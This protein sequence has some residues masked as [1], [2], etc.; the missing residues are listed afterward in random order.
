MR[1][2]ASVKMP[3]GEAA[4]RYAKE[5]AVPLVE[6]ARRFGISRERVRQKWRS[7]YGDEPTPAHQVRARREAAIVSLASQGLAPVEI[8]DRLGVRLERVYYVRDRDGL[9]MARGSD[10]INVTEETHAKILALA[11]EK[12]TR[13]QIAHELGMNYGTICRHLKGCS[14]RVP[15]RRPSRGASAMASDAMDRTG[16]SLGEAAAKFAVAPPALFQYRKRRGLWTR[17]NAS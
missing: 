14:T 16:C 13:S 12:K 10:K 7:I 5:N 6:A 15:G 4:A 8:A 17:R 2:E 11:C 9:A 1:R 3:R